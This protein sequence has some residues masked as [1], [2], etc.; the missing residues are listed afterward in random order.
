M[1]NKQNMKWLLI[2]ITCLASLQTTAYARGHTEF[3]EREEIRRTF[4]L[5]PGAVVEV[6]MIYGP[7][8]IETSDKDEAEVYVVR[9]A[10]R[11]EDFV[12]RPISIEQ[13][14]TGLV[15]RGERDLSQEPAK[16]QHHVRLKLPRRVNLVVQKINGHAN[17]GEIEG[18]VRLARINGAAIVA[19]ASEHAEISSINGSLTMTINR[20]GGQG[21]N[22]TDINGAVEFRLPRDL[23][24]DVR[25]IEFNGTVNW[26][27]PNTIVLENKLQKIFSARIG[28]GGAPITITDVNGSVRL[29]PIGQ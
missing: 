17:I 18:T 2:V 12:S 8:D 7:V 24:A 21:I 11:R 13:T 23:E 9:T 5:S 3:R 1:T 27:M 22:A 6:T 16:V 29:A 19:K 28:A 20:V 15:V 25:I 10:R 26:G 4:R 14:S